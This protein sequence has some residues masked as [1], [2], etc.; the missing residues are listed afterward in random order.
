MYA[1]I[2]LQG[3]QFIVNEGLEIIVDK[4]EGKAGDKIKIQDVLSTFDEE[5]KDV[6]VGNPTVKKAVV[7]AEIMETKKGKKVK[8][9]KFKN[10]N[11]Y[12]R[13]IGFRPLQTILKINK[14][15][16]DG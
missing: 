9:L 1:V 13:N 4:I 10:K 6:K 3:H 5:A 2:K 14:I 16:L 11:R 7:E 8:V 12:E 15:K